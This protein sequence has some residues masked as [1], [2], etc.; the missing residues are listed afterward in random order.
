MPA[1]QRGTAAAKR[2]GNWLIFGIFGVKIA[3]TARLMGT[4]RAK[5]DKTIADHARKD[6]KNET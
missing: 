2:R 4:R 1:P 5:A 3:Y 6:I